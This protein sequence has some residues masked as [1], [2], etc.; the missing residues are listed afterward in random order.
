MTNQDTYDRTLDEP[1]VPAERGLGRVPNEPYYQQPARRGGARVAGVVLLVVGLIWLLVQYS[2]GL[3]PFGMGGGTLLD[4]S[5]PARQLV[6]DIGT[7]DVEVRTWDQP[8]MRVEAFYRGGAPGDYAVSVE[9]R[10]DTLAISGGAKPFFPLFGSRDLH[11]RISVPVG[12][13][14]QIKTVNGDIDLTELGGEINLESTNGDIHASQIARGL[15]VATVNGEIDL[16]AI[17]GP[18]QANSTNGSVTLDDGTVENARVETVNGDVELNGVAGKLE[19]TSVNGDI[20]IEDARDGTLT[21]S[22]TNSDINYEGSLAPGATNT[23]NNVSGDVNMRL[24]ENS[25]FELRA[26]TASGDLSTDFELANQ[27]Q[28]RR[29]LSGKANNGGTPLNISTTSGD[30]DVEVQ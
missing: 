9:P 5:Y 25:N 24:S 11:Y 2:D 12:A 7:G 4:N 22:A 1:T 6:V 26:D 15:T 19:V 28:D 16:D 21:L 27:Q 20:T 8:T 14:A 13:D 18:L 30:I 29:N 23:V 17:S 10:G 3:S